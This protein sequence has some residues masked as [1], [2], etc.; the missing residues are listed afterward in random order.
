MAK[1]AF[2]DGNF[3][4]QGS[5]GLIG[6]L[7]FVLALLSTPALAQ[8]VPNHAIPIGRGVGATVWG[9]G[10][11]CGRGQALVWN[12]ETFDAACQ[13]VVVP[14]NGPPETGQLLIGT[15]GGA[16]VWTTILPAPSYTFAGTL[17]GLT[18]R[19]A[20]G[21]ALIGIGWN[22]LQA[23]DGASGNDAIGANALSRCTTCSQ[24]V[25][26]GEGGTGSAITADLGDVLI[27][28]GAAITLNYTAANSFNTI[29][30]H[31]ACQI[32]VTVGSS[33]MVGRA[34]FAHGHS[35]SYVNGLGHA[36]LYYGDNLNAVTAIGPSAGG[37]PIDGSGTVPP[38][39]PNAG[40]LI[41]G[42]DGDTD[43][44]VM[45]DSAGK[46]GAGPSAAPRKQS[47]AI[48]SYACIPAI[49][50]VGVLG[51]GLVALETAAQLWSGYTV[52]AISSDS[53]RAITAAQ[54]C[55]GIIIRSGLT[56]PRTDT[57]PSAADIVGCVGHDAE[58]TLGRILRIANNSSQPQTIAAGPGGNASGTMTIAG[59]G[60]G[61][62]LIQP[63]VTAGGSEAYTVTRVGGASEPLPIG[64]PWPWLGLAGVAAIALAY[65][66]RYLEAITRR[67]MRGERGMI[68]G[69][70]MVL[71]VLSAGGAWGE[72]GAY[73]PPDQS[74]WNEMA[75]A[76]AKLSMPLEAHQ[77]ILQIMSNVEREAQ[78]RAA[79]GRAEKAATAAR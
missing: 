74:L 21:M 44:D 50:N 37:A 55:G 46:C 7:A 48:G 59:N 68:V 3:G 26:I 61:E 38:G 57:L 66:G 9:A 25:V 63:T 1:Q 35:G 56:A 5:Q 31:A 52:S 53:N 24:N 11:P 14:A 2:L 8:D 76:F 28:F 23:A 58:P 40:R 54:A 73:A 6:A 75:A 13:S 20:S 47:F 33:T 71:S 16:P 62:L 17:N 51:N 43:V 41:Y 34:V 22:A 64:G 12:A 19:G 18:F 67:A 69:L 30:G 79:R 32:C 10:G 4:S 45:G 29:V 77:A 60:Y 39:F 42:L 72:E 49:D 70:A 27:G 36:A 65:G 78:T 15:T